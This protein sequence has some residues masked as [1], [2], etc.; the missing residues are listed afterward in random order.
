MK[1]ELG[2]KTAAL[3][4]LEAKEKQLS[5]DL[6][7]TQAELAAKTSALETAERGLA[8]ASAAV[9]SAGEGTFEIVSVGVLPSS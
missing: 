1:F 9:A 6:A 7:A 5:D 8:G 4:A 3:F 2:E